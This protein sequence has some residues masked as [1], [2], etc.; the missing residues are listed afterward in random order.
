MESKDITAERPAVRSSA[1]S[2]PVPVIW[3]PRWA[4]AVFGLVTLALFGP[5]LVALAK[6]ALAVDLHSHVLLIPFI[7]GY[8]IHTRKDEL[9]RTFAPAIAAAFPFLLAGLGAWAAHRGVFGTLNLSHNDSLA[10]MAFGFVSTVVGGGFLLFGS[11]LMRAV[12]FPAAFLLF[13][14]PLPDGWVDALETASKFASADASALWF[15]LSG[16]P[17]VRDGVIF[18]LPTIVI[19]VAQECSGIRSSWV[20]FIT[21]VLASNMLLTTTWRRVVL[22]AIVIPLGI[23][24]NGFR[25]MFIGLLCVH[26]HPDMI[27]SFWHK[28]GGPIFF[29]MALVPFMAILWWLRRGEVKK[30]RASAQG[31]QGISQPPQP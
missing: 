28:K 14:I 5:S 12:A 6:H 31:P 21:G 11:A 10:L 29:V 8:L 15:T 26:I 1:P 13:M 22:V 30:L 27:H 4:L 18:Q 2:A 25:I 9:P 7:S 24:R 20:L 3:P 16:T 19:E 23:L 17:Y